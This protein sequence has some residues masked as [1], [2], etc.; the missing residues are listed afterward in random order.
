MKVVISSLGEDLESDVDERFGR[1]SYFLVIDIENKEIKDVKT[2]ENTARMQA[3]GAG[4]TAAEIVAN[5]KPDAIITG[6]IG[7]KAFQIFEQLGIKI[8]QGHGKIKDVVQD[9]MEGKLEELT[10]A[11]GPQHRYFK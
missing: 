2:I 3:G 9:F 1:C 7:P 10:G 6:N 4:I 11:T 5:E 8:Y